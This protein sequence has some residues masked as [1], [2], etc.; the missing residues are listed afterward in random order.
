M[1]KFFIPISTCL[2][3][4]ACSPQQHSG[5]PGEAPNVSVSFE[6]VMPE[7]S[8]VAFSN[9]ITE[10][11]SDNYLVYDGFYQGA[12]V[13]V[14]DINNDGLQD[15]YLCGNQVPDRLY[16]NKGNFEF[17]DITESAGIQAHDWSTGVAFG[18]VNGDGFQDIYVCQFLWRDYTRRENKLYINN[19]DNTFTEKSKEWGVADLGL[20]VS[21]VFFD[22]DKDED[23]DLYVVNQPPNFREDRD[24]FRRQIDYRYTGRFYVNDN[25]QTFVDR[26]LETGVVNFGYGLAAVPTDLNNDG[27][28]D[29]YCAFDYDEADL[30]FMNNGDGT[31]TNAS[32][33]ALAHMSNFSMGVDVGD[34][35]NDG[36]MDIFVADMVAPDHER[37]KTQMSGMNPE[38]FFALVDAGYHRQY[39]FNS[40]QVNNGVGRFSE[41]GQLAGVGNTDWS[42]TTFFMD[43]DLDGYQDLFVSNGIKRDVR[44]N[45][46]NIARRK[47]VEELKQ[48]GQTDEQGRAK[49]DAM[50]LLEMAPSTRLSNFF[51]RNNGDFTFDDKA[52][53]WGLGAKG[54]SH[55]GVYADLDN[56]GDLDIVLNNMDEPAGLYRNTSSG[57]GN[58]LMVNCTRNGLPALNAK[59]HIRHDAHEQYREITSARGYMSCGQPIAHFGLGPDKSI[60]ELTVIWNDG[61]QTIMTDVKGNQQINIEYNDSQRQPWQKPTEQARMFAKQD[62]EI[63]EHQEN[64]YDDYVDEILLPHKM[65]TVGS[66]IAVADLNGDG[67]DDVYAGGA[68]GQAGALM[69]QNA[70]GTFSPTTGPWTRH[71]SRED[72]SALFFDADGDGDDDLYVASGGNESSPGASYYRDRLYINDGAGQFS[73]GS[74]RIPEITVSSGVVT[75]GDY[76]LDGDMDLFV[77]GRQLPK[78][79]PYPTTSFVLANDGS[80]NF[81]VVDAD[82][83]SDFGMVTDAQWANLDDDEQLELVTCGEWM[84]IKVL[85][86]ENGALKDKTEEYGLEHSAGWWNTVKVADVDGDGDMDLLAGNLG[87][88]IKY[89]ASQDNPFKVYSADFD[90]NGSNDIYLGYYEHGEL[91]PV[92]GRQCSSQQMP[93]IKEK[94]PTYNEF[95]DATVEEILGPSVEG[96]LVLAAETFES[97]VFLNNGSGYFDR[98]KLPNMAQFSTLQDM[99]LDDFDNDGDMD[100]LIA[101]NL[102]DREVETRRSDGSVGLLLLNDGKGNFAEVSP[103]TS[104]FNAHLDARQLEIIN[105]AAGQAVMVS[106]TN[107]PIQVFGV[108]K[109]SI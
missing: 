84:P 72:N 102:F 34:I 12:G 97:S 85:D 38:R 46:Y 50:T 30:M 8:G 62:V 44:D 75:A 10:D 1:Y 73:D 81:S 56:D 45:D 101:G 78:K 89:K 109:M 47:F 23:L 94:F 6:Q 54:W 17:E 80:G 25:N 27:W 60:D 68:K 36:W 108:T 37:I 91:F 69:M 53:D 7:A 66:C 40:L 11:H 21:A 32:N 16:L 5:E 35:N 107:G 48:Q 100:L 55:G 3:I 93:F 9:K 57:G 79:W 4:F 77:G 82:V 106:N 18:D 67:L 58:Y 39:M 63:F 104:G 64:S 88:N 98:R 43:A 83:L 59:V 90:Q 76:D 95:A 52:D 26:T 87:L 65:S 13:G 15:I 33:E 105:T 103:A 28:T 96:A 24:Q 92:R 49:V 20:S 74:S 99:I 61:T 29:L 14:G 41:I 22:F 86:F 19:G 31:F 42:W 70:D 71:A 2:L 51:F